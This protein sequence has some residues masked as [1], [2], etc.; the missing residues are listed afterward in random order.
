VKK[1]I[2]AIAKGVMYFRD[3]KQES[4]ASMKEHLGVQSDEEA[5]VLWDELHETFAAEMP[6]DL[7]REIF[8]SRRIDMIAANEW[9]K[10]KPLPDPEQYL[11]R[12]MLDSTLKAMNYVP[13]KIEAPKK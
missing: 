2:R 13:A 5:S 7:Y 9:P 10:D 3:H 8:E 4:Y 1:F 11:A 12:D 6:A